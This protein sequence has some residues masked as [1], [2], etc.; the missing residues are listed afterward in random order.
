MD[1]QNDVIDISHE[2]SS[3]PNK[4][5]SDLRFLAPTTELNGK[6]VCKVASHEDEASTAVRL[7]VYCEL[8]K[9]LLQ[10]KYIYYK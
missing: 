5:H 3:E 9:Y 7:V 8:Q 6:Y 2:A 10:N 4:I 1:S